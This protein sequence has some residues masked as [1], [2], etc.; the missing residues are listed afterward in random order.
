MK[1]EIDTKAFECVLP[2]GRFASMRPIKLLDML[3]AWA[4]G[5]AAMAVLAARVTTIDGRSY[6]TEEWCEFDY[7]D[8]API[9]VELQRRLVSAGASRGVA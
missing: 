6:S 9:I 8:H 4:A 5:S 3:A 1:P 7:L 2:D